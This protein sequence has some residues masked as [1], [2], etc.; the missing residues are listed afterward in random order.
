MPGHEHDHAHYGPGAGGRLTAA[1]GLT[2]SFAFVEALGGWIS[3]SLALL[4]DAGHMLSDSFA[5]GLAALAAWAIRQPPSFRHSYGFGRMEVVAALVNALLMLGV[6][7]GIGWAAI[8]R[9]Q[10]PAEVQGGTVML[11]AAVGLAINLLVAWILGHGE[12]NLNIRGALLHVMSDL[13]GSVAAL[14]SGAVIVFTGWTPIDPILALLVCLLILISTVRL[15]RDSLH[16]VL[17]G[18]P[19]GI[20]LPQVGRAMAKIDHVQSVHDLH[21]WTLSSGSIALSA[22]VVLD[23]LQ[24]WES[25]L[26]QLNGLLRE[27]FGIDHTTIQP[28]TGFHILYPGSPEDT[29]QG[30]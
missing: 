8:Q 11:I 26:E 12:Q 29:G 27:E 20:E 6:V 15:L 19:F 7:G 2:L 3:G 9:F 16:V 1:L 25:A 17:E 14:T 5:L 24:H 18:V 21:I 22:H 28:E 23:G 4:G 10:A 30:H 13:L